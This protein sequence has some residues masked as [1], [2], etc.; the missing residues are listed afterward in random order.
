MQMYLFALF[1][2]F[3]EILPY[4]LGFA[5]IAAFLYVAIKALKK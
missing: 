2:L 1:M 4:A 5:A 3:L